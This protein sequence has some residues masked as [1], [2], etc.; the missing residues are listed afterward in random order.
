MTYCSLDEARDWVAINDSVD[1]AELSAA[2]NAAS[3]AIDTRCGQTFDQPS[4]SASARLFRATHWDHLDLGMWRSVVGDT[5]GMI[6]KTDDNDDGAFETTWSASDWFTE[7]LSGVGANGRTGWPVTKIVTTGTRSFPIRTRR[8]GVQV[9]AIWGW[10]AVPDAITL[11]CRMLTIAWHARRSTVTGQGG[12]E[13]F[14]SSAISDDSTISD[15]LEP[16]RIGTAMA[17]FA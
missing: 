3:N 6:V 1:D 17:G 13:N 11:A 7:P 8:P 14:F 5:A 2:L 9:T 10:A 16:Y 15:L 12:F 4:G